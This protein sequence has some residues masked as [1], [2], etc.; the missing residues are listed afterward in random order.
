[1]AVVVHAMVVVVV[2]IA[3]VLAGRHLVTFKKADTE[4]ERQTHLP[5][6]RAQNPGLVLQTAQLVL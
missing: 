5:L 6:H 1:M 4:Q 2:A 3:V